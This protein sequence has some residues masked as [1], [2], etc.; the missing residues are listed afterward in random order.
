MKNNQIY[1]FLWVFYDIIYKVCIYNN[2]ILNNYSII[3]YKF[4]KTMVR[5]HYIIKNTIIVERSTSKVLI[6]KEKKY[7]LINKM[8][9][10]N[11]Q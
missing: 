9:S 2:N 3:S 10:F 4:I 6:M 7:L 5:K 11:L 1:I 8:P